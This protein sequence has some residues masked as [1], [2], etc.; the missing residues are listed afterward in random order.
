MPR[1]LAAEIVA[2]AQHLVQHIL[3]PDGGAH[4]GYPPLAQT[5]L[6][7]G[8]GHHRADDRIMHQPSA[9]VHKIGEHR[10]DVIAVDEHTVG[11]QS[12]H[13]VRVAVE[14]KH[15]VETRRPAGEKAGVQRA[16]T[17][18]DVRSVAIRIDRGDAR[19]GGL[20]R[21][22]CDGARRAVGAIEQHLHSAKI[23][24]F[25]D[26]RGIALRRIGCAQHSASADRRSRPCRFERTL[27]VLGRFEPAL[28][29]HFESVVFGGIVRRADDHSAIG[30]VARSHIRDAGGGHDSDVD[31]YPAVS[32]ER[33]AKRLGQ[34]LARRARVPADHSHTARLPR[35]QRRRK[36]ARGVFVE[37]IGIS[38][39]DAVRTEF[40]QNLPLALPGL[41]TCLTLPITKSSLPTSSVTVVPAAM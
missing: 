22:L 29:E 19:A 25:G 5:A 37:P 18:V 13:S 9:F 4:E 33:L 35:A 34:S 21:R 27:V 31:R 6:H 40:Q 16:A 30:A 10:K 12:D 41:T 20:E 11:A 38:P 14:R 1:L 26:K 32:G 17:I 23:A 28:A 7:A 39:S 3:V 8:V 36:L 24:L 15:R 2:L